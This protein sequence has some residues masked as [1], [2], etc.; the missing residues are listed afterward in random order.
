MAHFS[1]GLLNCPSLDYLQRG[2]YTAWVLSM[3]VSLVMMPVM[4]H[5]HALADEEA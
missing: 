1:G 2:D 3:L 5:G 4:T